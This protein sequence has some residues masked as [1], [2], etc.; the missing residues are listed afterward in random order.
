[1]AMHPDDR[2]IDHRVFHVRLVRN[3]VEHALEYIRLHLVAEPLEYGVPVAKQ[4]RQITPRATGPR[5][6]QDSFR[7]Q[8]SVPAGS[9]WI[10][11]LAEAERC[12]FLPLGVRQTEPFHGKLLSELESQTPWPRESPDSQHALVARFEQDVAHAERTLLEEGT[13]HPLFAVVDEH[14]RTRPVV[15]DFSSD[16]AKNISFAIVRLMCGVD[17]AEVVFHRTEAWLVLGDVAPGLN[18]SQSE[19][20]IEVLL[21]SCVARVD[22]TIQQKVHVREIERDLVGAVTV[23]RDAALPGLGSA[24]MQGMDLQGRIMDL[25]PA[26]PPSFAER[27]RARDRMD[28]VTKRLA[29]GQAAFAS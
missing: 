18:A 14:G 20:R 4:I 12:H 26:E 7:E 8:T 23:L 3:R 10:R 13:V 19:R 28:Q 2:G 16:E 22:G 6:P 21:V 5:N 9:T 11:R 29:R 25:L 17:A 1:M 27:R 24:G 15:A